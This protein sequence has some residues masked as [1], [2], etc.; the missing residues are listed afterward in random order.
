MLLDSAQIQQKNI[1]Q[2]NK[3]RLRTN[4]EPRLPLYT[5]DEAKECM[6]LFSPIEYRKNY[7]IADGIK[8]R[9]QDAGHIL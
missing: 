4:Q 3:R 5:E 9:F 6:E 2:E 1:E 7:T 8:V